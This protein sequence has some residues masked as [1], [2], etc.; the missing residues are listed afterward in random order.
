MIAMSIT[1]QPTQDI[2]T[3]PHITIQPTQDINTYPH[4][5]DAKSCCSDHPEIK[6]IVLG[7]GG[8]VEVIDIVLGGRGGG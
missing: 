8:V 3:Y 2:N 4:I 7:G 5:T 1:I 6:Y